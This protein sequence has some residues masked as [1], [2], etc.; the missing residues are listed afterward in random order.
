MSHTAPV[1]PISWLATTGFETDNVAEWEA[2]ISQDCDEAD[3]MELGETAV[4]LPSNRFFITRKYIGKI[5]KSNQFN[6]SITYLK[7]KKCRNSGFNFTSHSFRKILHKCLLCIEKSEINWKNDGKLDSHDI[8]L[9][10]FCVAHPYL[11]GY[12]MSDVWH[13]GNLER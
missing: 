7:F 11:L 3:E 10:E 13:L 5:N 2:E 12:E 9:F 4:A 1:F 8:F 6:K